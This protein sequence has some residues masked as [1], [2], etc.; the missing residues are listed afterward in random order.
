M[1]CLFF[2]G[3]PEGAKVPHNTLWGYVVGMPMAWIDVLDSS[4]C[5]MPLGMAHKKVLYGNAT[6]CEAKKLCVKEFK[7]IFIVKVNI[8][9]IKQFKIFCF[10]RLL[11]VMFLLVAD[12]SFDVFNFR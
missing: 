1:A 6:F 12:I 9:F 2:G 5:V 10:K 11:H 4:L 7:K 3:A 8:K